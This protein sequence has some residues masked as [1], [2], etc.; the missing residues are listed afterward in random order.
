MTLINSINL[1][2]VIKLVKFH[3]PDPLFNK[4]TIKKLK[5]SPSMNA[6]RFV[7]SVTGPASL[8]Q[9][10]LSLEAET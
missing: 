6:K 9:S 2:M 7:V 3:F 10:S 4:S 8:P 1:C 5:I